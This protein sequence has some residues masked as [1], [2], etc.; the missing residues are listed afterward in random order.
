MLIKNSWE[1]NNKSEKHK[2]C[3]FLRKKL[4]YNVWALVKLAV[5]PPLTHTYI[6]FFFYLCR[7]MSLLERS[8]KLKWF[9]TTNSWNNLTWICVF[10]V[11][12]CNSS[13]FDQVW[14]V[15]DFNKKMQIKINI[16]RMMLHIVDLDLEGT[17]YIFSFVH[18]FDHTRLIHMNE[19]IN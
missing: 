14:K 2:Q 7:K 6:M 18:N 17:K 4:S 12:I 9:M 3:N 19:M 13:D 10:S 11:I 5:T 15:I 1:T 8:L 16:K